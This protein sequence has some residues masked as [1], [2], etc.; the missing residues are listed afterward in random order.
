M[1]AGCESGGPNPGH[2]T[3]FRQLGY[4]GISGPEEIAV[5]P[6]PPSLARLFQE[7]RCPECGN[8][9]AYRSRRRGL[10]EKGVLRLLMMRP[11]RCDRCYHRS[12]LLRS[13]P[14]PQRTAPV[15]KRPA[16]GEGSKSDRR[17]A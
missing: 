13:V 1:R 9:E 3:L 7:F 6:L 17:V 14:L 2:E 8:D 15:A 16:S 10:L 4:H 11:V 5:H 12:Y